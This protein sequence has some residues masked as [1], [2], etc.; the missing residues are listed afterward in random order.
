MDFM[1]RL[2]RHGRRRKDFSHEIVICPRVV[3]SIT[4]RDAFADRRH[5]MRQIRVNLDTAIPCRSRLKLPIHR[6]RYVQV[7]SHGTY[8]SPTPSRVSIWIYELLAQTPRSGIKTVKRTVPAEKI[9]L[10]R[11]FRTR[12]ARRESETSCSSGG[13]AAPTHGVA[14]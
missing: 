11:P 2:L 1:P 4:R 9:V 14:P 6:I 3:I 5:V 10:Y 7:R 8:Y 12:S 13:E